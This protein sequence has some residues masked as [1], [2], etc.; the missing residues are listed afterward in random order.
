MDVDFALDT[1]DLKQKVLSPALLL[2]GAEGIMGKSYDVPA[3]WAD[4][5]A[6]FESRAMPGG[7]FFPDT[8]PTETAQVLLSFLRR[9]AH[10]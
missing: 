4:Q 8:H 1:A 7:H 10:L 6:S 2:Y 9:T 5:L 3:T